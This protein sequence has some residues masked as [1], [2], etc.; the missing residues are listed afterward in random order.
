[1]PEWIT[2]CTATV[3]QLKFRLLLVWHRSL[4]DKNCKEDTEY[5]SQ[6]LI[7]LKEIVEVSVSFFLFGE[8][9]LRDKKNYNKNDA[10]N[11]P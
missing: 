11:N 9:N 3:I 10:T 6:N 1:M 5:Q 8:E 7:S 2:N 4:H